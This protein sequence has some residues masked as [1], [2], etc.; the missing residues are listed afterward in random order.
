[1]K[2]SMLDFGTYV[3]MAMAAIGALAAIIYKF[4]GTVWETIGKSFKA[5]IKTTAVWAGVAV[6][7]FG[8]FWLGV[9][10]SNH[11][12]RALRAQ[13][14]ELRSEL[15]TEREAHKTETQRADAAEAALPKASPSGSTESAKSASQTPVPRRAVVRATPKS[16]SA[17][18]Q[19][20]AEWRPFQN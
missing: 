3:A 8:G 16:Q 17:S 5:I 14:S 7:T 11:S 19:P 18:A 13:V 4:M 10:Q 15:N 9:I 1:M 12:K 2:S 6:L 20:K